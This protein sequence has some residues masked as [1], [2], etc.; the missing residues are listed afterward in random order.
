MAGI[1]SE[2]FSCWVPLGHLPLVLIGS[3]SI[4]FQG[5]I[6]MKKSISV[7]GTLLLLGFSPMLK[8]ED[9]KVSLPPP[10]SGVRLETIDVTAKVADID[11]DSRLVT[12][13]D[14]KGGTL[15][16]RADEAIKDLK[17][18]KKGDKVEMQY[19]RSIAWR[20]L[21]KKVR[22]SETVTRSITTEG[23]KKKPEVTRTAEQSVIATIKAIDKSASSVT[24]KEPNAEPFTVKVRN[25]AVL[26]GVKVGEQVD[27]T[28]TELLAIQ[29]K[30][31]KS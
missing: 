23:G 25:P 19:Q 26:E 9:A 18:V 10:Q 21:D 1:S 30:K 3:L 13:E 11:Y 5:G 22:P 8:A 24:L 27:L 4:I 28:Y 17:K 12:L 6:R 31:I 2:V 16:V 20:V 14:A 15:S 29:V 7:W